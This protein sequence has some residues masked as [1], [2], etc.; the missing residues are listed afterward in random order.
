MKR[1]LVILGVLFLLLGVVALIHPTFHYHQQT[2]V[3]KIGSFKA[4]VDE[5]KSAEIPMAASVV[6]LISGVVLIGLGLRSN[7]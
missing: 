3:A 2:E 1:F 6:L 5:R 7:Q 4:T